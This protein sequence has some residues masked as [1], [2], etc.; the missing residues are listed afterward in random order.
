MSLCQCEERPHCGWRWCDQPADRS[1]WQPN[2]GN[3][4]G[5]PGSFKFMC[6][7]HWGIYRTAIAPED[8]RGSLDDR[9]RHARIAIDFEG[10]NEPK[11][12]PLRTVLS[13]SWDAKFTPAQ[14]QNITNYRRLLAKHGL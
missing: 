10:R 8:W 5:Y 2:W 14:L 1:V 9:L 4:S 6:E 7:A 3:Q 12:P 11:E 13:R